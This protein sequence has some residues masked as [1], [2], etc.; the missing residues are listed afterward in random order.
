MFEVRCR[1]H[2]NQN[3]LKNVCSL[4][5]LIAASFNLPTPYADQLQLQVAPPFLPTKYC[6]IVQKRTFPTDHLSA[7]KE[8]ANQ[9]L[10]QMH[11]GALSCTGWMSG[12]MLKEANRGECGTI[13]VMIKNE[14]RKSCPPLPR[15]QRFI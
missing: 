10:K 13:S 7:F 3:Q 15:C 5:F 14:N 9:N 1:K 11:F 2:H 12:Y 6:I 4:S 8:C